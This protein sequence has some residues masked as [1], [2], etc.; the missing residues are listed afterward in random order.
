M[1]KIVLAAAALAA[2][3]VTAPAFAA[4]SSSNL[5]VGYTDISGS[6]Y[7]FGV[8]NVRYGWTSGN[9]GVEGEA[10]TGVKSDGGVKISSEFGGFLTGQVEASPNFDLFARAGYA[11]FSAGG[12]GSGSNSGFA[13]GVGAQ[14]FFDMANGVRLEYTNYDLGSSTSTYGISYVRKFK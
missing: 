11:T 9:W 10:G 4:T 12:T 2:M 7:N 1:K 8:A 14:W 13:Y 5:S 3:A 6:G